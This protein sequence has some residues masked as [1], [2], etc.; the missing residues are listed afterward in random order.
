MNLISKENLE[1]NKYLLTI[2][3]PTEEFENAVD[4]VY[5]KE[6][7]NMTVQGFRKGKAPRAFVEKVYG[8]GVFYD[9]AIDSLYRSNVMQAVAASELKVVAI[10][11]MDI[12]E[13]GKGKNFLFTLEVITR[14][15]VSIEGYKGIEVEAKQAEV[16]DESI[17]EEIAKVQ[18]R[19]AR[20][21]NIDDRA[22]E[23]GDT[24]IFD[25]DGYMDGEAFDGG[26]SE[27]FELLLGSKHFIPG[28]EEQMVGHN[29]GE[30]FDVVLNFPEDYH[31][32]QLKGKEA[33]FK[34][35]LKE[36]KAKELPEIDDEFAKDVSEFD[37]LEEYKADIKA[38]LE[39]K[40]K[41]EYEMSVDRLIQDALVEKL[42]AEVPNEMV[43][44]EIDELLRN[45]EQRLKSQGLDFNTYLQYTGM[46]VEVL[47]DQQRDA[48]ARGVRVR[49][50]LEKVAELEK[51]EVT[52]EELEAEY[53][54]LADMHKIPVENIKKFI[55]PVEL[56]EDIANT[57]AIAL[58]KESAVIK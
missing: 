54:T 14:P 52:D 20:T 18:D 19:N 25:F 24:V 53:V 33:V 21:I 17:A 37:S 32:E 11:Q 23:M 57:K 48:A 49:L 51:V 43:E 34:I 44:H 16:T 29:I 27:D 30:D 28:F 45:F 22:A 42:V 47:R 38:K 40:N 13:I 50:A 2:E 46:T 8:E 3:V 35:K 15:E 31:A 58:I 7:K 12:K 4:A 55:N 41:R 1:V 36:I 26:K 39:V 10:G 9:K 56:K 6:V 5:K